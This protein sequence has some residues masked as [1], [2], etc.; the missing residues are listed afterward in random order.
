MKTF[1]ITWEDRL[2]DYYFIAGETGGDAEACENEWFD[3]WLP[4]IK[5][6]YSEYNDFYLESIPEDEMEA[7][8][9]F[10]NSEDEEE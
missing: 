8:E 5:K 6:N 7:F 4:D 2:D 10:A 1:T 3:L 9:E